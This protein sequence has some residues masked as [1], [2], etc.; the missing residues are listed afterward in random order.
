MNEKNGST[1]K[2]CKKKFK[3]FRKK[4]QNKFGG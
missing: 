1:L 2:I 3:P 4:Y